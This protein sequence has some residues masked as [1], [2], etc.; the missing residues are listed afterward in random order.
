MIT[1]S[2]FIRLPFTPDLTQAGIAYA[3]RSLAYTYDRMGGSPVERL[4]RITSGIAVE[5]AFRR[6]LIAAGV[7]HDN[8]GRT[9]FTDPDHYDI[10]LGGRQCDLKSYQ[11]SRIGEIHR[12]SQDPGY[13][14]EAA[15]LVP[16]DQAVSE[17]RHE[18][19][20]YIFAF[21][22]A[23][24]IEKPG[25][26]KQSLR[27]GQPACLVHIMP[28]TWAQPATWAPLGDLVFKAEA[29][30]SLAIELGGQGKN[31]DFQ[32]ERFDL[33]PGER[34]QARNTYF[35]L[36]YLRTGQIVSGRVGVH[37]PALKRTHLVP[38]GDWGN[39]WIYG[40]EIIFTGYTT[41]EEYRRLAQ[42]L[43]AG[44]RVQQYNRTRTDNL[45][46]PIRALHPLGDLFDRVKAW[47]AQRKI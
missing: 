40:M 34:V 3:C 41:Q 10:A 18:S 29:G 15:A 46:L 7:P 38:P 35:S 4:R 24:M 13:L 17:N 19:G 5:L 33:Q 39:I 22:T 36:A 45:S 44:S 47:H 9:P 20:L 31:R 25:E 23:R 42:F 37:S 21:S 28:Q 2:D 43:P 16:C 12:V 32:T 26:V 8:S 1:A 6:R 27:D 14:L 30:E 11:V